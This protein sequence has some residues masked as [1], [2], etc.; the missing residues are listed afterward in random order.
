MPV[1]AVRTAVCYLISIMLHGAALAAIACVSSDWGYQSPQFADA[2]GG[3]T[4]GDPAGA[5]NVLESSFSSSSQK[6]VQPLVRF[7]IA[8]ATLPRPTVIPQSAFAPMQNRVATEL[9]RGRPPVAVELV[10]MVPPVIEPAKLSRIEVAEV[11]LSRLSTEAA[12]P[13][14]P[15]RAFAHRS[16]G[17]E[18]RA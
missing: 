12:A 1:H 7:Q 11:A 16:G 14:R 4:G 13:N 18:C 17:R 6:M 5:P 9:V 8:P 2:Q 10:S 3:G 15:G